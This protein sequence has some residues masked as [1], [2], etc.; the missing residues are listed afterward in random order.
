M[1]QPRPPRL[2]ISACLGFEA[3]RYDGQRVEGTFV[4]ALRQRVDVV[5]VCPE[6]GMGMTIPRDPIRL[7]Q[8]GRGIVLYQPS[9]ATDF[10]A[11]MRRS[12]WPG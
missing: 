9:T 8:D 3:C 1:P 5:T 4:D 2:V 7:V 10:T 11:A 6:V 12:S